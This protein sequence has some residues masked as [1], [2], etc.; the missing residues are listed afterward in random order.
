MAHFEDGSIAT[1]DVLI[2]AD[3]ANSRVHAQLLPHAKRVVRL[4]IGGS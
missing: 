4:N 3:G 1:G 2:G